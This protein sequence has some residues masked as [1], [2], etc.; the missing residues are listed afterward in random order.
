[1]AANTLAIDI[2]TTW[3][4]V[5]LY[6]HTGGS[7]RL[8][9]SARLPSGVGEYNGSADS[10]AHF[11]RLC[12]AI[13]AAVEE[14]LQGGP[15]DRIG[16]TGIREGLVLLD[17]GGSPIWVSGNALLDE[18]GLLGLPIGGIELAHVLPGILAR[19]EAAAAMVTLQGYVASRLTGRLAMTASELAAW[20]ILE[21]DAGRVPDAGRLLERVALSPVGAPIGAHARYPRTQVFLAGTDEQASHFGAGV[22]T[23]ADLG[24]ATATFWSLTARATGVRPKIAEV[25][26]LPE[27]APYCAAAT[28]IGYRW[29]PFLQAALAGQAPLFPDR[30]PVWAAGKLLRVL[31]EAAPI[32]RHRLVDAAVADISDALRILSLAGTVPAKPTLVVHGG[33]LTGLRAFTTEV[34]ERLGLPWVEREGDPTQLGC[35][36]AGIAGAA[37]GVA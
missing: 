21:V 1:M 13:E 36:L 26:Y 24:L 19:N 23:S 8:L 6:A 5:A 37:P 18:E 31:R 27:I 28:V 2:G 17:G 30:L 10:L 22:G 33:G 4:K 3:A 7:L 29:G 16:L 9:S 14:C 12:A 34:L 20:G 32:P 11:L 35:C 25:R 15:V